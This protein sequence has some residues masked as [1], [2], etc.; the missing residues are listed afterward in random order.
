MPNCAK[1]SRK[2]KVTNDRAV[3][4]LERF[5]LVEAVVDKAEVTVVRAGADGADHVELGM[6]CFTSQ[7]ARV[8]D[9]LL[10]KAAVLSARSAL[11]QA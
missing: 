10:A 8:L 11:V 3:C 5:L 6:A 4:H 1:P 2:H 7:F 9:E